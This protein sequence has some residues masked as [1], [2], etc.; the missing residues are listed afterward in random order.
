MSQKDYSTSASTTTGES[1][2]ARLISFPLIFSIASSLAASQIS[3]VSSV[4]TTPVCNPSV[5]GVK[6]SDTNFPNEISVP[7][8][9]NSQSLQTD[10]ALLMS[11]C[12]RRKH[13]L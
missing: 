6:N 13:V 2:P 10:L 1:D 5:S 12:T 4:E 9:T 8:E 11:S 7:F 3:S